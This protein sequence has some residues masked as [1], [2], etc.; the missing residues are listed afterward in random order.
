M[1]GPTTTTTN[2]G[3]TLVGKRLRKSFGA[4][5]FWGSVVGCYYIAEAQFYKI[6]FD[7]GD[8][9]ILAVA[10]VLEDVKQVRWTLLTWLRCLVLVT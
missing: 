4:R 5:F 8:V 2:G 10:E 7:D 9:D 6:R 3:D 1:R